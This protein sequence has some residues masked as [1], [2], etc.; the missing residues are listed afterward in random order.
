MQVKSLFQCQTWNIG[1]NPVLFQ[2][3]YVN[4]CH[5]RIWPI[6]NKTFG[7]VIWQC[8][9]NFEA[10]ILKSLLKLKFWVFQNIL[11]RK[12]CLYP[13]DFSSENWTFSLEYIS[14]LLWNF[15][16]FPPLC[17]QLSTF[18]VRRLIFLC[19]IMAHLTQQ[20]QVAFFHFFFFKKLLILLKVW[21]FKHFFKLSVSLNF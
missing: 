8:E 10:D 4:L 13:L 19:P 17:P 5:R 16:R 18:S 12:S 11:T 15:C 2:W 6:D 7:H 14:Y 3:N 9:Q 1:S 21:H 20:K